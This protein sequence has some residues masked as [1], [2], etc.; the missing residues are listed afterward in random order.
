[1]SLASGEVQSII[2]YTE[3]FV[4]HCSDNEVMSLP[5]DMK[6]QIQREME[7]HSK[8]ERSLEPEEEA[9]M[10]VQVKCKEALQGFFKPWLRLLR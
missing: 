3:R 9:D 5:A 10:A 6:R 1:M 4:G 2:D 7:E 8:S